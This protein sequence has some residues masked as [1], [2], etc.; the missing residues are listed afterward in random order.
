MEALGFF[1]TSWVDLHLLFLVGI[2]LRLDGFIQI[3]I[4]ILIF[5]IRNKLICHR[6]FLFLTLLL[7]LG[8]AICCFLGL[9]GSQHRRGRN[10]LNLLRYL[11]C[12]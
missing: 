4:N 5:Q 7:I 12:S 8:P 3:Y 6:G 11:I 2:S 9:L 1:L 10:R